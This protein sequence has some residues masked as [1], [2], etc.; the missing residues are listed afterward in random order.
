[1]GLLNLV[2]DYSANK[3]YLV[4][5][6]SGRDDIVGFEVN[7][8]D[9]NAQIPGFVPMFRIVQND[10]TIFRYDVTGLIS[11]NRYF[12][13]TFA[14]KQLWNL[15]MGFC[16]VDETI[17]EYMLRSEG[18]CTSIDKIY[19]DPSTGGIKMIY[20]P[21]K[22]SINEVN[23]SLI[24]C[25]N[26]VLN[27][28]VA[29]LSEDA[30]YYDVWKQIAGDVNLHSLQT[31]KKKIEAFEE[32]KE[33]RIKVMQEKAEEEK[34]RAQ[35]EIEEQ[36]RAAM[37]QQ[38]MLEQQ[39][40]G[41]N[42]GKFG[43]FGNKDKNAKAAN[44]NSNRN[45]PV[46]P[47]MAIPGG[48]NAAMPTGRN[49]TAPAGG[50]VA[51]P[52][53]G[54]MAIPGGGNIAMPGGGSMAIPG[55]GS[56]A[57]P[58][59]GAMTPPKGNA[60]KEKPKKEKPQKPVKEKKGLFGKKDKKN[61]S[62][63]EM[64]NVPPN[65]AM[66]QANPAMY[67]QNQAQALNNQQFVEEEGLHTILDTSKRGNMPMPAAPAINGS[68][69]I[70]Q[71]VPMSSATNYV[72]QPAQVPQPVQVPQPAQVPQPVQVPSLD[73][74]IRTIQP[75][76]PAQVSQPVQVSQ[77][78][79]VMAQS[80]AQRKRAWLTNS[81]GVMTEVSK[82]P[83]IVGRQM[84]VADLIVENNPE[85]GRQHMIIT[86]SEGSYFVTD[87]RSKNH[88]YLNGRQLPSEVPYPVAGGDVIV[89]GQE[90]ASVAFRFQSE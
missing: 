1:M 86:Y 32:H 52:G 63:Q 48:G 74:T 41:N 51:M 80:G 9:N 17:E 84:G 69:P 71:N 39:N 36:E 40:Q 45:E 21:V 68:A 79:N 49:T 59:G 67:P 89:L 55:G 29:D 60:K 22:E 19:V 20:I 7:M 14:K 50:S 35:E 16:A 82:L 43:L 76:Q 5:D 90:G 72:P 42:K 2:E 54:S 46:V 83:F 56:M 30:G 70:M 78:Q 57:I 38:E 23:T 75:Q 24:Q 34:K 53:G 64:V 33:N 10:Q 65:P 25:T 4:C 26:I 6:V 3:Q 12:G 27:S 47:G 11:V 85:I 44:A 13:V 66:Y 37:L 8:M 62:A 31:L 73:Q 18:L 15:V 28:I 87:N 58:G 81:S 88:T 77:V 61:V